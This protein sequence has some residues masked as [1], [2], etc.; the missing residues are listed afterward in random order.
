MLMVCNVNGWKITINKCAL[1]CKGVFVRVK[2]AS[3]FEGENQRWLRCIYRTVVYS[4]TARIFLHQRKA[5][6]SKLKTIMQIQPPSQLGVSLPPALWSTW[7]G[8]MLFTMPAPPLFRM[9]PSEGN[10]GGCYRFVAIRTRL[11]LFTNERG[12]RSYNR[13]NEGWLL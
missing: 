2:R 6:P 3:L 13:T 1:V 12:G 5:S 7:I 4:L 8:S 9:K 10:V 11:S